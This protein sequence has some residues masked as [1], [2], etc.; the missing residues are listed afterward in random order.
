MC[1]CVTYGRLIYI[2]LM[3]VSWRRHFFVDNF[4]A[5]LSISI[6]KTRVKNAHGRFTSTYLLNQDVSHA[7]DVLLSIVRRRRMCLVSACVGIHRWP[8][9]TKTDSGITCH[10]VVL[11]VADETNSCFG[12]GTVTTRSVKTFLVTPRLQR[13]MGANQVLPCVTTQWCSAVNIVSDQGEKRVGMLVQENEP[14]L[15]A[16]FYSEAD[17]GERSVPVGRQLSLLRVKPSLSPL[18]IE[19]IPVSPKRRIEVK[20]LL[21]F[22]KEWIQFPFLNFLLRLRIVLNHVSP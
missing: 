15:M 20:R 5:C 22:Q 4:F 18:K 16:D 3:M 11:V 1:R 8:T 6:S 21:K 2:D 9:R 13:G 17:L 12:V 7:F 10:A 19:W 14:V